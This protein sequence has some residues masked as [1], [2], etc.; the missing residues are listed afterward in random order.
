MPLV[1]PKQKTTFGR[2]NR[3]HYCYKTPAN[4]TVRVIQGDDIYA[5]SAHVCDDCYM[6]KIVYGGKVS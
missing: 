1:K 4:I 2:N 5:R 3:C 6:K